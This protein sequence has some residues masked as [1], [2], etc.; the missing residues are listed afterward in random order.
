MKKII[1]F[2]VVSIAL[3]TSSL[4]AATMEVQKKPGFGYN[5][6]FI[7]N[8]IKS[9]D[10]AQQTETI[11]KTLIDT[12]A[13]FMRFPGG[14]RSN[15]FIPLIENSGLGKQTSF[16]KGFKNNFLVEYA[17]TM[18]DIPVQTVYVANIMAH[19]PSYYGAPG[20]IPKPIRGKS[21]IDLIEMN[22]RAVEY[23]IDQ[24]LDV[25]FV[26][27]GNELYSYDLTKLLRGKVRK[28]KSYTKVASIAAPALDRYEYLVNQYTLA[29]DQL[30][31]RKSKELGRVITI[32]TGVLAVTPSATFNPNYN[33]YYQGDFSNYFSYW[34]ERVSHMNADAVIIHPYADTSVCV[35]QRSLSEPL[36]TCLSRTAYADLQNMPTVLDRVQSMFSGKEIWVTEYNVALGFS[37]NDIRAKSSYVMSS[38][39]LDYLKKVSDLF[40]NRGIPVYLAHQFYSASAKTALIIGSPTKAVV[41]KNVCAYIPFNF[42]ERTSGYGCK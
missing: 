13:S 17:S 22:V 32:K 14:T 20:L 15:E 5:G 11:K 24:G 7:E 16:D 21:D 2:V 18:K 29:F 28:E 36:A 3:P 33:N 31:E 8:L 35:N 12:G 23:L 40:S 19:F 27:L 38:D 41:Q 26:E 9:S 39:H 4:F 10:R 1:F 34:N 37:A 6:F 30:A 42:V 25:P